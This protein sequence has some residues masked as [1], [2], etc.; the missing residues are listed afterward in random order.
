MSRFLTTLCLFV[1]SAACAF[2]QCGGQERWA[3]KDGTDDTASQ[4]QLDNITD[5]TIAQLVK[6]KQ[7]K[8]AND[9]TTRATPEE[10]MVVRVKARLI[11][12]KLESDQDFHVVL[13]DDTLK[14]TPGHGRPTGHSVI[15]EVPST[16][17]LSGSHDEF[18]TTSPLLEGTGS[19]P[20]GFKISRQQMTDE[21]PDA[22]L[23]G[24]W[25]DG[26]GAHVEVVGVVFFDRA[27]GQVGR[28][29][30]NLEIHPILSIQF[31]DHPQELMAAAPTGKSTANTIIAAPPAKSGQPLV[32][33]DPNS[34]ES[35]SVT[36]DKALK[37]TSSVESGTSGI[38]RAG[39]ASAD[40]GFP[41]TL[42]VCWFTAA[43]PGAIQISID[44]KN[45]FDVDN[46]NGSG[47]RSVPPARFVK[48]TTAKG[49]FQASY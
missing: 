1:F 9:N 30:N 19:D 3:V 14:F 11:Q 43:S 4:V 48:L 37:V 35:A 47:C 36:A 15:G 45:W 24:G 29:P 6:I 22:D 33:Q 21:F 8:I 18:G 20:I 27:H 40:L 10:T 32:I 17:C 25:N 38:L 39:T 7:P 12:W 5:M 46:T 16:D 49:M 13:T 31:L 41:K 42:T 44:G 34:G 28:A 23:S 26:G 2:A